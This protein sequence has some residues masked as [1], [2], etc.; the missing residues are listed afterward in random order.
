[1]SI[2]I[3]K[4]N[5]GG[6]RPYESSQY[7]S[8]QAL[9]VKSK[10]LGA[11]LFGIAGG[12][13]GCGEGLKSADGSKK[14]SF[15][16]ITSPAVINSE[17]ADSYR[18]SGT[19]L[20]LNQEIRVVLKDTVRGVVENPT[21]LICGDSG[22]WFI[23]VD[24]SNDLNDGTITITVTHTNASG[25][26][27][28]AT[29][30]VLKDVEA[31]TVG[32][33]SLGDLDPG[34]I[35]YEENSMYSLSGTCSDEGGAIDVA[36]TDSQGT[37]VGTSVLGT[38][39]LGSMECLS[40]GRWE[41]SLSYASLLDGEVEVEVTHN[42]LFEN[43]VVVT[44]SIQKDTIVPWLRITTP[45]HIL[46]TDSSYEVKGFCSEN[47]QEVTV[48]D[49]LTDSASHEFQETSTCDS[50][51]WS[52]DFAVDFGSNEMGGLS[53]G[54]IVISV[55]H[56]DESGNLFE[57]E[58]TVFKSGSG[59]SNRVSIDEILPVTE[60]N[61]G[62][63]S[64]E[65][66]CT[67]QDL[68]FTLS[69]GGESPTG[70][71]S[72]SCPSTG[73]WQASFNLQG[74]L[75][76][77]TLSVDLSYGGV[78]AL[79]YSTAKD[80]VAPSLALNTLGS[81]VVETEN[82]P[83]SISGTCGEHGLSVRVEV[84]DSG[85]VP[86]VS[87]PETDPQC[88]QGEWS[89]QINH[90]S[91]EDGELTV[92]V[93]HHDLVGN[94]TTETG[95]FLKDTDSPEIEFSGSENIRIATES[96]YSINGTCSDRG[97]NVDLIF[98]DSSQPVVELSESVIC[99]DNSGM[100]E[101]ELTGLDTT[102]LLEGVITVKATHYDEVGN[103]TEVTT[104][105]IKDIQGPTFQ[106]SNISDVSSISQTNY[107]LSGSCSEIGKILTI[108]VSGTHIDDGTSH[109][110]TITILCIDNLGNGEWT[111]EDFDISSF[112]DGSLTIE[113][114][115]SDE[116]G[117]EVTQ[118]HIVNKD[119]LSVAMTISMPSNILKGTVNTYNIGGSCTEEGQEVTVEVS[120]GNQTVTPSS[121]PICQTDSWSTQVDHSSLSEGEI[122]ISAIHEDAQGDQDSTSQTILKD[123][124]DPTVGVNGVEDILAVTESSYSLSGTCSDEGGEVEVTLTDSI[125]SPRQISESVACINNAG[126]LEW[127]VTNWDTTTLADGGISVRVTHWDV[128]GNSV[129]DDTPTLTK[130]V[131]RPILSLDPPGNINADTVESDIFNL[132]GICDETNGT[133]TL[134]LTSDGGG[135][136]LTDTAACTSNIWEIPMNMS[137]LSDGNVTIEVSLLD[138][139]GNEALF[140]PVMVVKD[141]DPPEVRIVSAP[142][143]NLQTVLTQYTL[144]GTCSERGR[145]VLVEM[146]NL[147]NTANIVNST[148][149]C[150]E[151]NGTWSS[152]VDV[153][154]L[155]ETN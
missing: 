125:T 115:Y 135:S 65:G 32:F 41:V 143:I 67:L 25:L 110:K 117:N 148:A 51:Q 31:P 37:V 60:D 39:V 58:F 14:P 71:S 15:V 103:S 152:E 140:S 61:E 73:R 75:D 42:D 79:S 35:L 33:G 7:Q 104:S 91:L 13:F 70:G 153:T 101:W 26:E 76:A 50:N 145:D 154:N 22:E 95:T 93:S 3:F 119:I 98:S 141:V 8:N 69:V 74:I 113:I 80:T 142:H 90:G 40:G 5:W 102:S 10:I 116:S 87:S 11:I 130:D 136:S 30:E 19:C 66:D 138:Q 23:E 123:L 68:S 144:S 151:S 134:T 55:S 6:V 92:T 131:I 62:S 139:V 12:L 114:S 59:E 56:W 82:D 127:E 86:N 106:W 147:Y 132:S 89:T 77:E 128:A 44:H 149:L 118:I 83:Y 155:Q 84:S 2:N 48:T 18:V 78:P 29:Q 47:T 63:Y 36:F 53:E 38:S 17:N 81:I 85:A 88:F 24:T 97:E 1:M 111:T 27:Y 126:D 150:L 133:V 46:S 105:M 109:S 129:A 45:H 34:P 4:K 94:I 108:N 57:E 124:V 99:T 121:Q 96:D 9:K 43:V 100:G 146:K 120:D 20:Y 21:P 28:T 122:T 16:T 52:V 112:S 72:L 137:S 54:D 64:L 49:S 107:L